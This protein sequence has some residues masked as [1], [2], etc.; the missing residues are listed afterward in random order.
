MKTTI[1]QYWSNFPLRDR[2]TT[3]THRAFKKATDE[4]KVILA[5]PDDTWLAQLVACT[6]AGKTHVITCLHGEILD[7]HR[8]E[9][10][11]DPTIMPSA[12][13]EMD[14]ISD[15]GSHSWSNDYAHILRAL[16]HPNPDSDSL[17]QARD[18]LRKCLTMRRTETLF[19][20]EAAHFIYGCDLRKPAAIRRRADV[21]RSFTDDTRTRLVLCST[22]DLLP[23]T[24]IDGQ[25]IRRNQLVH[26]ARY[27]NT[28]A[29]RN[30]FLG[31]L[32]L[33]DTQYS[34][35]LEFSL[36]SR[37]EEVYQGCLGLVGALRNWLVRASCVAEDA[38][39]LKICWEDILK[40]RDGTKARLRIL[41]EARNGE[42]AIEDDEDSDERFQKLLLSDREE[43]AAAGSRSVSPNT[44]NRENSERS[45]GTIP[46]P[47]LSKKN[48][49]GRSK[50][51]RPRCGDP[52]E[53]G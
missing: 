41:E 23:M 4:L 51:S 13:V 28:D 48:L 47:L 20:D 30:T 8:A 46:K 18:K 26:L 25:I 15:N 9:M 50:P 10:E 6:G 14:R 17:K 43:A 35:Y 39:R 34:S 22:Y 12:Y 52:D 7:R 11:A 3:I 21:I 19:L 37:Q 27:R 33:L 31:I 40:R 38:G 16:K 49:P 29:D 42:D 24:R 2:S 45:E 5:T 53:C 44:D 32:H 1:Q 36:A